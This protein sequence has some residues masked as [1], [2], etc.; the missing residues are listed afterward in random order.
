MICQNPYRGQIKTVCQKSKKEIK[1]I[2]FDITPPERP[3]VTQTLMVNF[4]RFNLSEEEKRQ[5][6]HKHRE[7]IVAF[8][9]VN[10]ELMNKYT[11]RLIRLVKHKDVKNVHIEAS[12][13]GAFI[14]LAALYSGK[15]PKDKPV[16]FVL[17]SLPLSLFPEKWVFD[18]EVAPH[19]DIHFSSDVSWQGQFQSF[20]EPPQHLKL[21]E[22]IHR[23]LKS[24][25]AA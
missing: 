12:D 11:Q 25:L 7:Q 22:R 23:N 15:F 17:T 24:K 18:V 6:S 10:D 8:Q 14:C 20:T 21:P 2:R 19:V 9:T 4:K 3:Q 1:N 13:F 5:L 16:N